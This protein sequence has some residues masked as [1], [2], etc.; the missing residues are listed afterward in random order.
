MSN[1]MHLFKVNQKVK[2]NVDGKFFNGT[3]K[4]QVALEQIFI[5]LVMSDST[6]VN[7]GV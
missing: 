2:C 6:V 7:N 3:V 1:L 4:E 5:D